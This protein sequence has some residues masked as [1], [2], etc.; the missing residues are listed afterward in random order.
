[1][2]CCVWTASNNVGLMAKAQDSLVFHIIMLTALVSATLTVSK[3]RAAHAY[4]C[5]ELDRVSIGSGGLMQP[6]FPGRALNFAIEGNQITADG[7]FYH[8]EYEI[9][10]LEN[11]DFRGIGLNDDRVDIF[12]L[13]GE[14]L[15]H[16][17][18]VHYGDTSSIQ[19]QVF[20]C[21]VAR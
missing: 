19:S 4:S 15:F 8:Q 21:V 7:V 18:I 11:G 17:A 20:S 9:E 6:A 5:I 12:R 10:P 16:S 13:E 14:F 1:M 3:A 2:S